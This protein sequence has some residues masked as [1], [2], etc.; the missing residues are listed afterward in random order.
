MCLLLLQT[1]GTIHVHSRWYGTLV[2]GLGSVI[3]L[4][5]G[6]I[7]WTC[8]LSS[9]FSFL[10]LLN[11][12]EDSNSSTNKGFEIDECKDERYI[13]VIIALELM[14]PIL[15]HVTRVPIAMYRQI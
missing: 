12:N 8:A 2:G 3:H 5:D 11:I 1:Q 9:L 14:L 7:S 15:K 6:V 10:K 4:R 13:Q